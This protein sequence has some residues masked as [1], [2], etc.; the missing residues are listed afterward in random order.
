MLNKAAI[1]AVVLIQGASLPALFGII[2]KTAEIPPLMPILFAIG[3]AILTVHSFVTNAS[4]VYKL[5]NG[6]G[7][8]LNL[9]ILLA[10][11]Y[12]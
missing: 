11:Y 2:N 5:A 9:S 10:I 6:C 8:S 1:L 3:L 7:L 12:V 4:Y